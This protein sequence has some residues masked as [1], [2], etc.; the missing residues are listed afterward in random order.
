MRRNFENMARGNFVV[1]KFT[2]NEI[3]LV[4]VFEHG[5]KESAK[6]LGKRSEHYER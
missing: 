3:E 4:I 1:S 2:R 6:C 5:T